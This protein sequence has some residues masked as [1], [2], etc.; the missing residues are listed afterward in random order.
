MALELIVT[1]LVCAKL[2]INLWRSAPPGNTDHKKI[3][4]YAVRGYNR[5]LKTD[6]A[7]ITKL[8]NEKYSIMNPGNPFILG[9]KGQRPRSQC[10]TTVPASDFAL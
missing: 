3:P 10:T 1:K 2:V 9:S 5:S 4:V 8:A 6:A 7:K